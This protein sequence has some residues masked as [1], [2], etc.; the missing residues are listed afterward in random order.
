[1]P[2]RSLGNCLDP[3]LPGT[4]L[5]IEAGQGERESEAGSGLPMRGV[6]GQLE[7]SRDG[8]NMNG[9]CEEPFEM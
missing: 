6:G 4:C 3:G 7:S 5:E 8:G 2:D 9:D 1:V